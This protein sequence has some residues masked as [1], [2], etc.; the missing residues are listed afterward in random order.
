[1][2]DRL[3]GNILAILAS[4]KHIPCERITIDSRLED[5]GIDSLDTIVLVCELEKKFQVAIPD[6][7]VRSIRSVRDIVEGVR[8]LVDNGP[9]SS[10]ATAS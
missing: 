7:Q 8:S 1:M 4:V 2:P 5:L 9:L 10:T 6:E 3:T